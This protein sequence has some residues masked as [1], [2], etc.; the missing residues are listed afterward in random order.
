MSQDDGIVGRPRRNINNI[1]RRGEHTKWKRMIQ[2]H[3]IIVDVKWLVC[4]RRTRRK[5]ESVNIVREGERVG[6]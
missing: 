3:W 1:A 6:E 5:K 4:E 2:G